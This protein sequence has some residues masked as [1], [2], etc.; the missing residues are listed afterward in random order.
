MSKNVENILILTRGS[1]IISTLLCMALSDKQQ[2]LDLIDK[3]LQGKAS[4][5]EEQL[6]NNFL[7]SFEQDDNGDYIS[8]HQ[9]SE[10]KNRML[11]RL[12]STIALKKGTPVIPIHRKPFFKMAWTRY[13]AA[14]ILL[15][16]GAYFLH[17]QSTKKQHI[18]LS[19]HHKI[20]V[21]IEAAKE[22]AILTLEDGSEIILDSLNNGLVT[23]QNG[24]EVVIKDG[25][26]SYNP[27]NKH[28]E[29]ISYNTMSTPRGR[30]FQLMLPDGT[31]VWLNAASSL[32]Y[33]TV[34]QG[35]TRNVEIN[36]EAYF[37]VAKN[38]QMPFIV[39][40]NAETEIKVLG[41]HFNVNSY[42]DEASINTSLLEGAVEIK[43]GKNKAFLKP[44]QQAQVISQTAPKT[45]KNKKD[46]NV[47]NNINLDKVMSWKNGIFDFQD[48][49][50][51]EVMRQLARWYDLQVVYEDGIP[52]MKFYGKMDRNVSLSR[53]LIFLQES[54]LHFRMEDGRKLIVTK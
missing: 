24:A 33:P 39:K 51:G 31:K 26:L 21:D 6:L 37:E 45:G 46:I 42:D 48:A 25:E 47:V 40:I 5:E 7:N 16:T 27:K 34:F 19:S 12:Q 44:G 17:W 38:S 43:N 32:R 28:A 41:T 29:K 35:A 14:V 50:L 1:V 2:F 22:G 49:D 3:Y 13:A 52:E 36:G 10:L 15:F 23:D 30:Q 4:L 9:K 53:L 11:L 20:P 54:D 18:D 8:E